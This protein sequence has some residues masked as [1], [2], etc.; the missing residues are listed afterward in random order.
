MHF[1]DY[2]LAGISIYLNEI[3]PR[4]K[5]CKKHSYFITD[6]IYAQIK[7]SGTSELFSNQINKYRNLEHSNDDV[8]KLISF[9][10]DNY[11]SLEQEALANINI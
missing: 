7:D 5:R 6:Y 2:D 9:I 1:G 3:I 8:S 11:R 10:K 4:L